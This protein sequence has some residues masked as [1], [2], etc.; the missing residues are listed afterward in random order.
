MNII[1]RTKLFDLARA[2]VDVGL[3]LQKGQDLLITSPIEALPLV[4]NI[5]KYAY[6]KGSGIITPF[7]YDDELALARYT[8]SNDEVYDRASTWLYEAMA[9]AYSNGA[10]RL[11]IAGDNPMLFTGIDGELIAR[12]NKAASLASKP[13]MEKITN[14]D[15]NWSITSYPTL[16][17]AK[18]VFPNLP[19]EKAVQALA[20][21]IFKASR[22]EDGDVLDNWQ[23]HNSNLHKR[24]KWLNEQNFDALHFKSENTDLKISLADDHQWQGGAAQAKNGVTCNAN[25]PTEE[26]FTTPHSQKVDGVVYSTKPLSYQG[27]LIENIM[28]RFEAGKVVEVKSSK[29]EDVLQKLL[30]SDEGACRLGEIALVPHSSPIS[31][32]GLLFYNTLYDENAACHIA[33]GQCYA[34]CFK[35]G[36]SLSSEEIERKGGNQSLI[37]VDWMIG[38]QHIDVNGITKSGEIVP[39]FRKGEWA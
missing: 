35:N 31:A 12:V 22:V 5:A 7:F 9:K 3:N 18:L 29:G 19:D 11:A 2:T 36:T 21:A 26:V 37:H 28:M 1:D 15:I 10:A 39:V 6:Q 8:N 23:Q 14:F 32:S 25:I 24:S 27:N 4:R 17:W 38:S 34:K 16:S 30:A 13:A 20:D 33:M